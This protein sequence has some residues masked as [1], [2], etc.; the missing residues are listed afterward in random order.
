MRPTASDEGRMLADIPRKSPESF[1]WTSTFLT[2][3]VADRNHRPGEHLESL[4]NDV[5]YGA[6][7]LW[8]SKGITVIALISLATGI[9]ANSAI[10][11]VAN[12]ILLRPRPVAAPEEIVELYSGHREIG[13]AAGKARVEI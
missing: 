1:S 7:M 9:G 10:F 4:I 13:R 8:K 3:S 6:R 5:R 12:S 2:R 11:S